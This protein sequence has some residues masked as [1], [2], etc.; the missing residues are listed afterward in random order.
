MARKMGAYVALLSILL[1]S[2]AQAQGYK[3]VAEWP[4][5]NA[6]DIAVDRSTGDVL[7]A[8]WTGTH[9]TRYSPDGAGLGTWPTGIKAPEYADQG[10]WLACD[11][12][13]NVYVLDHSGT[14]RKFDAK[15]SPLTQWSDAEIAP[16]SIAADA[17]GN[18]YV[19]I[20]GNIEWRKYDPSGVEF[21]SVWS[22]FED[23]RAE[24][25]A[26]GSVYF[27][28]HDY[29]EDHAVSRFDAFSGQWLNSWGFPVACREDPCE[30][31]ED[32]TFD[33]VGG[34][35]VDP[36]SGYVVVTSGGERIQFFT[37]NGKFVGKLSDFPGGLIDIGLN[38]YLYVAVGDDTGTQI[39]IQIFAP[40]QTRT[41]PA[42]WGQVKVRW[43]R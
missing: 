27:T 2:A 12:L 9:V 19:T 18:V 32:G 16:F 26:D 21:V 11:G 40:T 29:S 33:G 38:G 23:G 1:A 43:M 39:A 24:A 14:V 4:A 10:A 37:P 41:Q 22:A 28:G 25:A 6:G 30:P 31:P 3:L 34:L 8:N 15:G 20:N 17:D 35:A 7:V 42:S 36:R 13:G 5:P